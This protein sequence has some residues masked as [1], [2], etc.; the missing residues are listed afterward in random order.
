MAVLERRGLPYPA[1]VYLEGGDQFRGWF[2]SSLATALEVRG[3][4][5]YRTVVTN[6]WAVDGNGQKMAKSQG[7]AIEPQ[8]VVKQSGAEVLRLWCA[9]LD[10]HD[11]MRVSSEILN[12]IS[13][14]YR[15]IRNSARFALG[16]LDGFDP[17]HDRVAYDELLEIDR[18]AL[19]TL[20]EVTVRVRDAYDRFD[21][22]EVYQTIYSFATVELSALYF[23]ILKDRLYTAA[24]KSLARRSAQTV[25]HQ[26]AHRLARLVAPILAFTSD[27]IW[28]N[29]PGALAEAPS[30]HLAEFP[31]AEPSWKNDALLERYERLIG[32]RSAVLKAL[33][34]AR[35]S[36]LI[37]AG[38]EAR[39]VITADDETRGFLQ[40]FGEDLKYVF[41]VSEVELKEGAALEVVVEHAR[42]EKCERCWN[43][44]TDVG[45]DPRF[46]GACL[47]CVGN[48]D[49]VAG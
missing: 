49:E 37:G 19:A 2:N 4:A 13:E 44:T 12:R 36:K 14:A 25:L 18:W 21:F 40:S 8:T 34:E 33:E 26:I 38:L 3:E 48:L 29:I 5:P 17:A 41:I 16:N 9:A 30:V 15:K 11:D 47:R 28:E 23:D 35:A 42:G 10:Y 6:G 32:I 46:P 27:E 39:V 43:Y 20:N 24:T 45:A 7:N 1:D 22:T 31:G